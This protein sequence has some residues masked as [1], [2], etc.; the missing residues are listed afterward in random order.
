M[1]RTIKAALAAVTMAIA[2][3]GFT[4]A[5]ASAWVQVGKHTQYPAEGGTW[6]YGFYDVALRSYYYVG[7]CHGSTAQRF[8][9]GTMTNQSRSVD[10]AANQWSIASVGTVNSPGLTAAY[11]YRTC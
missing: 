8:I 5:P 6:E 2:V 10:T 3:L 7:L 9:D 1:S 4:A 11:Y